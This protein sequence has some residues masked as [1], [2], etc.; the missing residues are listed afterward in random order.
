MRQSK[1]LK[2]IVVAKT[3]IGSEKTL[4]ST[5]VLLILIKYCSKKSLDIVMDT[6]IIILVRSVIFRF[7]LLLELGPHQTI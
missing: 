6:K 1:L 7:L 2:Y 5:V 4:K 3:K